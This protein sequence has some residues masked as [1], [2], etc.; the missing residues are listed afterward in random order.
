MPESDS[1][2]TRTFIC[3]HCQ[4][5][6]VAVI[7]GIALWDGCDQEGDTVNPPVEYALL[8]CQRCQE[9]SVQMREDYGGGFEADEPVFVYPA[10]RKLSYSIPEPLRLEWEEARACFEAKAFTACIVIVRRTLEGTCQ[11]QGVKK[12]TLADSLKELRNQG[13]IDGILGEWA[14]ALRVVGNEGA[15]FTGRALEREDAE[16]ALAF[17]E[18][19]LDH[20]YVLRKRFAEFQGRL[21]A[22][23]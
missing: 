6:V 12:R 22:R 9:V 5:P 20:L 17:A 16:D 14:D 11:Q 18:A 13:L 23:K 3:P 19:L 4:K 2:Q 15:H 10:P 7:S 8:Q 1:V 21:S